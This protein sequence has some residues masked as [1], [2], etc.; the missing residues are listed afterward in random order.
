LISAMGMM[1]HIMAHSQQVCRVSLLLADHLD[2][3]G[4]NRELIRA[5]AL[6]HDITKTKS[7]QTL[8]DHAE[9]GARLVADLGYPEVGRIIG[10]HVRL[11]SYTPARTPS[12]AEVV[13]YA[14]KRVLHDRI[15]SL[16]ERMGYILEKYGR[17]PE[18]K[19]NIL[20]LWEK[21]K[22]MEERLFESLPFSP[23]D[24]SRLLAADVSPRQ[25]QNSGDPF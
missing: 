25:M 12:E 20:L 11:E 9:T 22:K 19:R 10:Q 4:L 18:R 8:E 13:N 1:E 21:T 23:G 5:A 16:D 3:S 24:I 14:D 2:H 6:L 17:A 15:V 7:F